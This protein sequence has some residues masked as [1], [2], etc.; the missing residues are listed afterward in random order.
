MAYNGV[1]KAIIDQFTSFIPGFRLVDGDEL[2]LL[3]NLVARARGGIVAT[4]SGTQANSI[5]LGI[6]LNSVDTVAT[7]ADGVVLPLA[8]PGA[9]CRLLNNTANAMQ[10]FGNPSNPNNAGAGDTI[11]L[12]GSGTYVATATGVSHAAN[13]IAVYACVKMGQWKRGSIT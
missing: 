4:P 13:S 6:G 11:A 10:V 8:I 9:T 7:G 12:Q 5:Q 3:A 2:K 1:L